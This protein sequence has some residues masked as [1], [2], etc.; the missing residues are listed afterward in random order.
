M[1]EDGQV[2]IRIEFLVSAGS[3]I[4]HGHEGAGFDVGRGVLPGLADVDEAG[5]VFAEK[6]GGIGGGDFVFEHEY[7]L[8]G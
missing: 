4:A 6:R 1:A 7:S 2:L 5:L 8:A 3:D